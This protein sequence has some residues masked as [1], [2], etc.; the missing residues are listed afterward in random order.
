MTAGPQGH[1][2]VVSSGGSLLCRRGHRPLCS[3]L[4]LCQLHTALLRGPP[5]GVLCRFPHEPPVPKG[6][7]RRGAISAS[8]L[9]V[10]EMMLCCVDRARLAYPSPAGAFGLLPPRVLGKA[11]RNTVPRLSSLA[12]ALSG[13][14][15]AAGAGSCGNGVLPFRR[16][17]LPGSGVR[18]SI[19]KTHGSLT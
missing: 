14:E 12:V 1:V 5:C 18:S 11:R 4:W 19:P 9:L 10:A 15:P 13:T 6:P 16:N 17:R 3:A 8:S 7:P 2:H